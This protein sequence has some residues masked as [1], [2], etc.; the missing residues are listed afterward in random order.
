MDNQ[1][2]LYGH[3]FSSYTWKA[4]IPLYAL[5]IPFTFHEVMPG[6]NDLVAS[7]SPLGKFPMLVDGNAVLFEATIIIEHLA[8]TR[9]EARGL[10]PADP[11]AAV[12]ARMLDRVFDLS[13]QGSSFPVVAACIANP[14]APD[15]AVIAK[16][17]ADLLRSYAWLENY[18]QT[19]PIAAEVNLVTC[20]AAPALFY[21]DWIEP[22][23]D[24]APRLRQLRADLLALPA[25]ARCVDDARPFRSWFPPGAPDRD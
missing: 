12:E 6:G 14:D 16:A 20:A 8:I 4:L 22:I 18:L 13:I 5:D 1:L 17:K 15:Q 2:E 19:R 24:S 9:P 7:A 23:P 10:I 21:A 11:A 3:P 25:V